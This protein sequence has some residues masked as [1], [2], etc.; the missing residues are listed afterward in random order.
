MEVVHTIREVRSAVATAKRAGR[1][2]RLVPTMGALHA[3]H[4]SLIRSAHA[5][6]GYV[7]VSVFVNPLQFGPAEDFD[8]YPRTL[9]ADAEV[10][11]DSG[12][13]LVF[14]P[15]ASEMYP[16]AQLTFVDLELVTE[17]LCGA[18][19]PG[20]FRGVATVVSK[21]LNIVQPDAA[22][23]GEKDAQQLAVIRRMV[24][25]LDFPI[26][27]H[28][29][30]TVREADGLAVSS[31]NRYLSVQEREAALILQRALQTARRLLLAGERDARRVR[32]EM[33]AVINREPLARL[34]YAE[35]VDPE[36]M[37]PVEELGGSVLLAVAA[38]FG[39]TRLI[40]NLLVEALPSG[41]RSE[42][43]AKGNV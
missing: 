4:A 2:V 29:V 26:E 40:D 17:T 6:G 31:R 5:A 10:C 37:Q 8:R 23:F 7:V 38:F 39:N 35:V 15:A 36:A 43:D 42:D 20:H 1:A 28:G 18:S 22:Y 11:R 25:D 14:A 21:L 24:K 34:D 33:R 41:A 13:D 30:P 32:E 19:R 3:G 12:A 16:R 9:E 27:V